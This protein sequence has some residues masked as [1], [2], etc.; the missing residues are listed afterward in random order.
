MPYVTEAD[1]IAACRTE[2]RFRQVTGETSGSTTKFDAAYPVAVDEMESYLR[3]RYTTPLDEPLPATL[4]RALVWLMLDHMA[5]VD[6]QPDFVVR[7]VN[8]ARG[9]KDTPGFLTLLSTGKAQLIDPDDTTGAGQSTGL[10]VGSYMDADGEEIEPVFD[11]FNPASE[12]RR[13][14]PEL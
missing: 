8:W 4:H 1:L 12:Y 14:N 7:G 10:D 2:A 13:R 3:G 9:T 6:R 5:T 11:R